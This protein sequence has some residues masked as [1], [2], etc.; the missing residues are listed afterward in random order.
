LAHGFCLGGDSLERFHFPGGIE[1]NAF[2]LP[3]KEEQFLVEAVGLLFIGREDNEGAL[4]PAED[5][6]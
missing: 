2:I 5:A 1:E 4:G 6:G 3:D